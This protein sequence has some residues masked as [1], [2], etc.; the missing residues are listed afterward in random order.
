MFLRYPAASKT[1]AEQVRVYVQDLAS[2]PA[3]VVSR[4]I[5]RVR[6][7]ALRN[8]AF[9]PSCDEIIKV[10][11]HIGMTPDETRELMALRGQPIAIEHTRRDEPEQAPVDDAARVRMQAKVNE[12]M[13]TMGGRDD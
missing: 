11:R 6:H 12:F 9:P 13:T 1:S 8:A 4:A 3:S 7:D 5:V 2:W 10:L